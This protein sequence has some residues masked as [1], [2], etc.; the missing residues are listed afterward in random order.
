MCLNVVKMIVTV[1]LL[2]KFKNK[3][4]FT[5]H[6]KLSQPVIIIIFTP[7]ANTIA[8]NKVSNFVLNLKHDQT[9]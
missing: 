1:N 3:S 7:F 5:R 4:L 9:T 2:L 6:A 8:G